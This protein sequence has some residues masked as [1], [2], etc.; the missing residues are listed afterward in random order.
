MCTWD[1]FDT[2]PS[3]E[4]PEVSARQEMIQ[5]N[6]RVRSHAKARL[7]DGEHRILD[8][9]QLEL[10]NADRLEILRILPLG[11]R[12]L[13]T[14]RIDELFGEHFFTTNFWRMWR[15]TFAFQKWHSAAELRRYFVRFIQEFPRI[16]TLGGVRRTKYDQY[17]SLV[18][19]L[20]R[21]LTAR[22]VDLRFG[23][24]VL[25]ADFATLPNG[26]RRVTRLRVDGGPGA[27][28]IDLGARRLRLAHARLDHGRLTL[29]RKRHRARVGARSHRPRVVALGANQQE[30]A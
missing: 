22:G 18:V 29:R 5:F 14:R 9:S 27:S 20:Q 2:I 8:A 28:P 12:A 13:G 25:D 1:L 17:D 19:P 6:E 4:D 24:R 23:V 30:G 15:T 16:H 7:I 21:W 11:D 3:L 26:S 10:S